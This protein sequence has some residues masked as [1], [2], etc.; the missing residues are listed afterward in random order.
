M[1]PGKP[2]GDMEKAALKQAIIE[3]WV[4]NYKR[5]CLDLPIAG[6][7]RGQVYVELPLYTLACSPSQQVAASYRGINPLAFL[8]QNLF[9]WGTRVWLD[10]S[11]L[12]HSRNLA[13]FTATF[14]CLLKH[15]P[16]ITT[17]TSVQ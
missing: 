2:I 10:G 12:P 6:V 5:G 14:E 7:R 17:E 9:L 1:L 4:R 11:L 16:D 15:G 3:T 13:E 8:G